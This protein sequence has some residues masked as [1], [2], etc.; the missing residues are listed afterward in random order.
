MHLTTIVNILHIGV[1]KVVYSSFR[2]SVGVEVPLTARRHPNPAQPDRVATQVA[3]ACWSEYILVHPQ[4][5]SARWEWEFPFWVLLF[6]SHAR[7]R[8]TCS[9]S[10]QTTTPTWFL[11]VHAL[12]TLSS[13]FKG[14]GDEILDP[15]W[16][17]LMLF[18]SS[19][20]A[21]KNAWFGLC[22]ENK[23]F[24]TRKLFLVFHR[25]QG[26]KLVLHLFLHINVL[27]IQRGEL[28]TPLT[29]PLSE[30]S[31]AITLRKSETDHV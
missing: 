11:I 4:S 24:S 10:L 29:Q 25:Y 18:P 21:T 1:A 13:F 22:C 30:K 23:H 5:W 17:E 26:R 20:L 8:F 12:R 14:E 15:S 9:N 6:H 7:S 31:I 16:N 28:L 3:T 19:S 2:Y 27:E